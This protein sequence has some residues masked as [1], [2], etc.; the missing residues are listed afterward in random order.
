MRFQLSS[1][2]WKTNPGIIEQRR[3]LFAFQT[4]VI[5][6]YSAFISLPITFPWIAFFLGLIVA[7][8]Q[9]QHLLWT[10]KIKRHLPPLTVPILALVAVYFVS[11]FV[12]GYSPAHDFKAGWKEAN[13]SL[14]ILRSFWVYFWAYYVFF[15]QPEA[16]AK[17]VP[18][19]LLFGAAAG[20]TAAVEQ[21]GNIHFGYQYLQ[22][23]G[24]LSGPM[25]FS[26]VMQ[27]LSL[28]GLGVWAT[29]TY[30][31]CPGPFKQQ[32]VFIAIAVANILGLFFAAERSGWLGFIAGAFV[33][34][35]LVS[36]KLVARVAAIGAIAA[37]IGW[38]C[39][40]M[41]QARLLPLLDWQH[42]PSSQ[43]RLAIW[44][45]AWKQYTHSTSREIVGVGPKKFDPYK[46]AGELPGKQELEHAHSNYL[47]S[48][49]TTGAVGLLV[50]LWLSIASIVL[51]WKNFFRARN[52]PE[53]SQIH[54]GI[55]LG[56]LGGLVSLMVAGLFEY[57]FGTGNVRMA[58][59][60]LLGLL[61]SG[62]SFDSIPFLD[63]QTD[64]DSK[65]APK[66]KKGS[67][68]KQAPPTPKALKKQARRRRKSK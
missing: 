34:T 27:L 5:A 61:S 57:N 51:A 43:Q 8:V 35:V 54:L 15:Y 17:V 45:H 59:W 49:T 33:V 29:G 67:T 28:L 10:Q 12:S 65:S 66:S 64:D 20:L 56:I 37:I 50:Y 36:R 38:F 63:R 26:G 53:Q 39:V 62:N 41:V 14:G 42:E 22:G 58:Q 30:K 44:D 4:W 68:R 21:L 1:E 32:R 25:A 40:P 19:A 23:T 55:S 24:F 2:E 7:V 11:G 46:P 18:S 13:A 6:I 9:W 52:T 16:E 3:K 47:Q 48:L 31:W 60:F